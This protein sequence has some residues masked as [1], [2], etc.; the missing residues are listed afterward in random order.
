MALSLSNVLSQN[1]KAKARCSFRHPT[2]DP[3]TVGPGP[4]AKEAAAAAKVEERKK[5]ARLEEKFE[6]RDYFDQTEDGTF[7]FYEIFLVTSN[8]LDSSA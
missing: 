8:V 7:N 3:A 4:D 6:L 5:K 1:K 2:D